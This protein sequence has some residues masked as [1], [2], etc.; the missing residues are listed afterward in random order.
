MAEIDAR[1]REDVHQ[2]G[3]LLGNT[4]SVQHGAAFLDKI[5]R[6]R[7]G[8]KA[9]RRGSQEGA[10][11]LSATLNQLDDDELLPV[12]RAF[13]QFL[14][15][16]NIA[17]QYHRVRRRAQ[18]EAQ[19]FED[20]I[21][22]DLLQRL[23][24]NGHKG[25]ALARQFGRLDIELVLTAHPTE[26]ARRT[27]I[28][29]Y[30]AMAEQLAA[31]DHSD[32]S[33]AEREQV[34][35]RLQRLI[36]EAW[37]T[38]EI[39]RSRPSPVDEAKW[40]FAVIEHSLWH[41]IPNVLRKADQVLHS[42][43]GLHLPLDA[44]PIRFASWMGGD[45]DGNPNVTASITREV[46]LLARWMAAD[47]YLRDVDNLAAELSMQQASPAL[48][49]R[50]GASAEPYRSLLKQ[51]RERLRA[52]RSWAQA[53]L[54]EQIPAPA[55]VLQDNRELLEPLTLCYQSL[56]EC[57]MGVIADG[58]LLD[59]LRRAATFGLFLVRLDVRQDSSRHAAA[60][61]EITD[62]LGLGRYAEWDEEARLAF[63]LKELENRRPLLPGHFKP[64]GE[65]E[66]VLATCREVAGA[67]A[68]SL[69]SYVISMAGAASDVLAVQLLLKEAGLQ[70]PMRVVPLFETLADLDN[71]GPVISRLLALHGYRARLHGPQEVMIGYSDSAKDAGTTAAAWAQYRAQET[72]VQVCREQDVEL[73]LFHGRGGTVGRGG[74]PAHAA[75]LSQPP[76]SVTGRFRT[77]EQGEMI[78][79]KFGLPDIAEQ[80]LNLYLAAVL[81]ATLLP[82]PSPE[83]A[84][85][86][87]MD[88][89]ASDGVSA[90]R[91]V[92]REHPQFVDY[93]RQ[94]TPEQE[95]GRLPLGSRPAKRREGGVES[96]RAI[97]WIFAWTQTRLMLPAWLGWEA[98]L[99]NAFQRGEGELLGQMRE[100]WPFFRTRIDMLEMVLAKADESIAQLYDE[101][102][103]EPALRPLGE[104]LRGLLSQAVVAV[105]GLTGQSQL[106]AHSPETLES[107]SV[108][109]TYLDPLHL[110][111]AELL[112]RSRLRDNQADSPLEQALLVSVAGIAAG[113]RNT[114]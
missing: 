63:L 84:W 59:C 23:S 45:R 81:E 82:P 57:G 92:V 9:S 22:A 34:K 60:M 69:G 12:A 78:R 42:A 103:V 112:A 71:A 108:R 21:L 7:K 111:Q 39:R 104:H 43:T 1:L 101:R 48:L 113:L 95:L 19:P 41:A 35:Q 27:L 25:E 20:N 58:P 52:T 79:F 18:G 100:H 28:Q 88:K 32:L 65:T 86:E 83:P 36:A 40:G 94:A 75:I 68:A 102:L 97:P 91:A 107:I 26:V 114:G 17:E 105:L 80:N 54:H 73:L 47:L 76:G 14:N 62:Y 109:N 98:A 44:A 70:R 53:A 10:E 74:G 56:H 33:A 93:F 72:L 51:L 15:L 89:L 106:L 4:I 16:A 67:P 66:E 5:E 50:V 64:S 85:R 77:T 31:G 90:Y 8:A 24:S 37:H 99:D 29:K 38:E 87:L 11:Q 96:L 55:A 110:L 46:L 49:A 3:E 61:S 30:D 2:L 13:N 6:I